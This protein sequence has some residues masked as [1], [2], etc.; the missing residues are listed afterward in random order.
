MEQK[1]DNSS[2]EESGHIS[3]AIKQVV[4]GFSFVFFFKEKNQTQHKKTKQGHINS[5]GKSGSFAI[6]PNK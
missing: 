3:L 4:V 1:K 6:H 5:N 2:L